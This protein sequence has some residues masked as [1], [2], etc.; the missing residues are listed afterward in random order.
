MIAEILKEC[1]QRNI[2]VEMCLPWGH[3]KVSGFSKSGDVEIYEGEDEGGEECVVVE[4][5]YGENDY[6]YDF[7]GLSFIAYRWWMQYRDRGYD[8]PQG[9][10]EYWIEKGLIKEKIVKEYIPTKY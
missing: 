4:Q 1:V 7:N 6:I 8:V 5:I 9:W 3:Y 2:H 10:K